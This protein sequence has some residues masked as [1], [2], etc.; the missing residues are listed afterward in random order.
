MGSQT[1]VHDWMTF[2]FI[3]TGGWWFGG[4]SLRMVSDSC[5]PMDC[6]LSG[7]SVHG[8]LQARILEWV[9]IS[10]SGGSS[11]PRDQTWVSYVSC[12]AGRLFTTEPLGKF[13]SHR[14][15]L[16]NV[17]KMLQISFLLSPVKFNGRGWVREKMILQ[18]FLLWWWYFYLQSTLKMD[19]LPKNGLFKNNLNV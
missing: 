17:L 10:F 11:W 7:S 9:S 14:Y 18:V 2:T 13:F 16:A 6:S 8:V 15:I 3:F 5:D 1:V 4:Y 19:G 12:I